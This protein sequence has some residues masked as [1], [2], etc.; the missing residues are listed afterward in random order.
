MMAMPNP[1][2]DWPRQCQ[3]ERGSLRHSKVIATL[4]IAYHRRSTEKRRPRQAAGVMTIADE[5]S[6]T[7]QVDRQCAEAHQPKRQRHW[8]DRVGYLP[9]RRPERRQDLEER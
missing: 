8:R 2:I 3:K 5:N 1:T 9:P 7:G 4:A 6:G